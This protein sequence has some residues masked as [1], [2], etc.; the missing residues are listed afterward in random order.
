MVST[1]LAPFRKRATWLEAIRTLL[2]GAVII[3]ASLLAAMWLDLMLPI[4]MQGR[5]YFTR[6]GFLAGLITIAAICAHRIRRLSLAHLAC[7]VDDRA[8]TG[9]EMLAGWQ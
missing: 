9:G 7:L 3:V 1:G 8:S 6:V 5:W 2:L 4:S